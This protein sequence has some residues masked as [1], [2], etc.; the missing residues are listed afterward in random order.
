MLAM[1]LTHTQQDKELVLL[2]YANY[3]KYLHE[4]D[5]AQ[6]LLERARAKGIAPNILSNHLLQVLKNS[7]ISKVTV[8]NGK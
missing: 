4:F 8:M 3:Y 6:K 5:K 7:D 1:S 2:A